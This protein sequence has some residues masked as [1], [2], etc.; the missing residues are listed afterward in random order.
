MS[1]EWQVPDYAAL[2]C[3]P[4][5]E[6]PEV[7]ESFAFHTVWGEIESISKSS[8][9]TLTEGSSEGVQASSGTQKGRRIS[10]PQNI[11][12]LSDT[13]SSQQ[14][15]PSWC[16]RPRLTKPSSRTQSGGPCGGSN[17]S[18]RSSRA[19]ARGTLRHTMRDTEERLGGRLSASDSETEYGR[20]KLDEEDWATL[21]AMELQW[22]QQA[23]PRARDSH[24][25]L[26]T[27]LDEDGQP[28]SVGSDRHDENLCKPCLFVHTKV[29]C[30]SGADCTF[31]HFQHKRKSKPRPCKGKRDRYRKLVARMED[32][33]E[34]NPDTLDEDLPELPPSI[35]ANDDLKQKLLT[36]L[37]T[38]A[39][40]VKEKLSL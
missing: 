13:S 25:P 17:R 21:L 16:S 15:A 23:S 34:Q 33:I 12:F 31:C 28:T 6:H 19:L 30:R 39:E 27:S 37:Q 22:R 10:R 36:R 8:A 4:L 14:S 3:G 32:M 26:E 9:V 2:G 35:E 40:M 5:E 20:E 7:K 24:S 38:H 11:Q 1:A 18:S 29:G